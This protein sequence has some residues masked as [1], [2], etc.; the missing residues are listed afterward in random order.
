MSLFAFFDAFRTLGT[1]YMALTDGGNGA[2]VCTP[3]EIIYRPVIPA[4]IASTAGAG[5]GFAATF[6]A[7]IARGQSPEDAL[8]AAAINAAS[9]VTY[10]DT[11]TGLLKRSELDQR[12]AEHASQSHVRRWLF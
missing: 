1:K 11:Q 2:F 10:A 12:F 5:D 6:T 4:K 3:T 7:E 8:L 9:V